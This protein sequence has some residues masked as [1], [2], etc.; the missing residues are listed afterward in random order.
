M[1]PP[2][3]GDESATL[4]LGRKEADTILNLLTYR[5]FT[6]SMFPYYQADQEGITTRELHQEWRE[7]RQLLR[8]LGWGEPKPQE[9]YDL[10][11][12]A[13]DI[14]KTLKRLREDARR[15]PSE[16]RYHLR[17]ETDAQ[18]R[19]RFRLAEKTCDKLLERLE[20]TAATPA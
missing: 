9:S 20:G 18:R 10:T 7:D 13:E 2:R 6:L 19:K 8:P 16:W 1:T 4:T 17:T 15:G 5:L 14:A 12:P 3:P 11:M